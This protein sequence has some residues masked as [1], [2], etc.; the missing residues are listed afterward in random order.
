MAKQSWWTRLLRGR[1]PT[2]ARRTPPA[3]R[4]RI[5]VF[6]DR[7]TPSLSDP[8]LLRGDAAPAAGQQQDARI[9][10]GAG[11]FL[12]VWV[13]D[14][15]V[16]AP[17]PNS[18]GATY[19]GTGLGS[20]WDVYAARLDGAGNVIDTAPIVVTQAELYQSTPRVAWNGQNWLVVWQTERE[21][22]RYHSDVVATRVAPDG[23]VLDRT[24]ILI[25][26][27]ATSD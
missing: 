2:T 21:D 23:T 14:R 11:G 7:L 13:D 18:H 5:E 6:E 16:T 8:L 19:T 25:S 24:P 3:F 20:L 27:G 4:S 22:D 17:V 26:A 1:R 9:A 12:T 10:A 15:S